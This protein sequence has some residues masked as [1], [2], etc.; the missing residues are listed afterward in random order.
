MSDELNEVNKIINKEKEYENV[1]INQQ[2][3][4]KE[5]KYKISILKIK[6]NELNEEIKNIKNQFNN[7]KS[8][9]A[10][11]SQ[12]IHKIPFPQQILL[13]NSN[14]IKKDI[15]INYINNNNVN[16]NYDNNNNIKERKRN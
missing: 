7:P 3:K 8:K 10:N 15:N 2:L 16:R 5:Y 13:N 6:V 1:I 12:F 11:N 4:L 14:E 9:M